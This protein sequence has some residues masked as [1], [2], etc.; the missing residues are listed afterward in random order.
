MKKPIIFILI[1]ALT[2]FT[3]LI[4][5]QIH[6]KPIEEIS[7]VEQKQTG[8]ISTNEKQDLVFTN[9]EYKFTLAFPSGWVVWNESYKSG[10]IQVFNYPQELSSP[11]GGFIGSEG[12]NKI[13]TYIADSDT[14]TKSSEYPEKEILSEKIVI[15]LNTITKT[16]VELQ[17]GE[18]FISYYV[19]IPNKNKFLN[20]VIY[21]D[22][23]NFSVLERILQTLAWN[24]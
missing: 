8:I 22:E 9:L 2:V 20:I 14:Y 7:S 12:L 3:V 21:G 19:K 5:S 17:G 16:Q 13:E 1:T 24:K 10:Y 4:F 23:K 18:K 11:K 15:G 6:K